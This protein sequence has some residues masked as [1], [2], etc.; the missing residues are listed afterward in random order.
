MNVPSMLG[1]AKYK[2]VQVTTS[3]PGQV[4]MMLFDGLFRFMD[5][6][7]DAIRKGERARAGERISRAHAIVDELCSSLRPDHA[8]ELCAKL[9]PLYIWA[10]GRLVEANASQSAEA[11]DEVIKVLTPIREAF[12]QVTKGG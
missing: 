10:M 7:A 8:P 2:S 5:E 6:A 4:L 12:R 3:S 1:V 11:V 9:Q